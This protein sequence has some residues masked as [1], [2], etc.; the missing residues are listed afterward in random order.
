M[1]DEI[2]DGEFDIS[3][4]K[5]QSWEEMMEEWDKKWVKKHPIANWVNEVLFKGKSIGGYSPH[6]ALGSF[7]LFKDA[8]Y[9]I[10]WANQ[11]IWRGYDDR[12][13]WSIDYYLDKMIPVWMEQLIKD[14]DGVPGIMFQDED[15]VTD[16]EIA[17]SVSVH[18]G[19]I[20][21]EAIELRKKEYNAILQ[22][23]AD[24]FRMHRKI[25]D[26]EFKR[27]SPAEKAAQAQFHEAFDLFHR[28]YHTLWD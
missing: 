5:K 25:S 19:E 13:V 7:I 1:T 23:I 22:K 6:Y 26:C 16:A 24:G 15:M 10:K 4:V 18:Q 27:G 2:E 21:D 20:K 9:E 3:K 28:F 12:V 14:K 17:L 8:W 11:R